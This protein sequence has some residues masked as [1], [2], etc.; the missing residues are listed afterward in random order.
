MKWMQ[1]RDGL[2]AQTLAFV[3]SVTGRNDDLGGVERPPAPPLSQPA[4]E[5]LAAIENALETRQLASRAPVQSTPP[6][7]MDP[8]PPRLS[9]EFAAEVRDR[10]EDFRR[11]Q[12]RF[13]REREE[14]F[15]S[16]LAKVRDA[17]QAPPPMRREK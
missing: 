4:R 7:Q 10:I 3:Q 17:I 11:H 9:G 2:I 8:P 12:E 13:R 15:S 1:E 16:T 6:H 14:Y 5:T